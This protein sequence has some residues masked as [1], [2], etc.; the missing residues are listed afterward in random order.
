MKKLTHVSPK[1]EVRMVDVSAKP[2]TER[3]AEA[4]GMIRMSPQTLQAIQGNSLA[5]G[6]V[7][8]V[9]RVAGIMAA[10]RTSELIPLCH[11]VALTDIDVRIEPDESLPGLRVS[12]TARTVAQTGVEM[13]AITAVAVTLVTLYDMAKS[14][15]KSM[16]IG[17]ICLLRKAGGLSG[18]WSRE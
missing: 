1:G 16:L 4:Q 9:S 5:K 8:T 17:D 15:D 10:K 18:E 14:V 11:P 3:I 6:D 7:L 12:A 13:E 2:P